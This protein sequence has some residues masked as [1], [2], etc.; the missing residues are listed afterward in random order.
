VVPQAR[1]ARA[2]EPVI[3]VPNPYRGSATWD[4]NPSPADP[5]GTKVDFLYLPPAPWTLRS[6]TLSGDLVILLTEQ[7]AQTNGHRQVETAEDGQAS[8]NL[9]SRN[10]QE[11]ASGIYLFSVGSAA[12]TQRGSFVIIR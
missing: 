1:T 4:L 5:S 6:F 12:G 10:G 9:I 3:V 7:D 11:V 2:G 8:W